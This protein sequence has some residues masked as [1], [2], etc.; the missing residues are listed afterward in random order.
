MSPEECIS[1]YCSKGAY[2]ATTT[3][4]MQG[5]ANPSASKMLNIYLKI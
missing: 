3:L 5:I 4:N 1:L 2:R